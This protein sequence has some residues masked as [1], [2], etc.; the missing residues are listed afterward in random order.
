MK[1][2]AAS[3]GV[4]PGDIILFAASGGE[5][6]PER[7]KKEL[8]M[9][10]IL[11]N[12]I[13]GFR[14]FLMFLFFIILTSVLFTGCQTTA[15]RKAAWLQAEGEAIKQRD[16]VCYQNI[17]YK[18][19]KDKNVLHY[20][21][22]W[23]DSD[24]ANGFNK[25]FFD[26]GDK[27]PT[28]YEVKIIVGIYN[29]IA[30]CRAQMIESVTR[31]DPNMVPIYVQSYRASDL[32]MAELIE[33]KI[34]WREAKERKLA[35]DN[36]TEQK[37]RSE[38]SR[39]ERELEMSHSAELANQRVDAQSGSSSVLRSQQDALDDRLQKQQLMNKPVTTTCVNRDGNIVCRTF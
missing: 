32:T 27:I 5:F 12:A 26:G 23:L 17:K 6:N 15:Q 3:S 33:R 14:G 38:L 4:S 2:P 21:E 28:D 8:V 25:G 22:P 35:L 13:D 9:L 30:N 19:E 29:D 11:R 24:S 1:L 34:S 10:S 31:I 20:M 37:I 36:E 7:L 39:L 16:R 18:H